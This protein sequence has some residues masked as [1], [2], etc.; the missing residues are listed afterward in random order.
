[1]FLVVIAARRHHFPGGSLKQFLLV[2][3]SKQVE[4]GWFYLGVL[5][6]FDIIWEQFK[7]FQS[8]FKRKVYKTRN[9]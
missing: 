1:M 2:L 5:W 6:S 8:D 3:L 4:G 9:M 7:T